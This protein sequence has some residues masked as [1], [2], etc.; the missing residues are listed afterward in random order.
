[1]KS[2][3]G[4]EVLVELIFGQKWSFSGNLIRNDPKM[5]IF[6]PKMYFL[7]FIYT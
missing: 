2:T 7:K 1:M 6:W 5:I 4:S 3:F